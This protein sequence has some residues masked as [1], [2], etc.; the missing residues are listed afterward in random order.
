VEIV[1]DRSIIEVFLDGGT[2]SA[3]QTFFPTESLTK[4]V[5]MAGG[6]KYGMEISVEVRALQS[7]WA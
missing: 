2:R 3:T 6:I 5:V 4:L 1:V 7:A